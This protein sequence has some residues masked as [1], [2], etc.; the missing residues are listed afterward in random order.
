MHTDLSKNVA[1]LDE[2]VEKV[3]ALAIKVRSR[4]RVGNANANERA[5]LSHE[6]SD[7]LR[8]IITNAEAALESLRGE[9]EGI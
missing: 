4:E 9:G 1:S 2:G 6:L 7:G 5:Q 8:Q 3:K